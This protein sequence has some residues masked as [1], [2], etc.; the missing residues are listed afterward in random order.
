MKFYRPTL[1]YMLQDYQY[2]LSVVPH[3]VYF[4]LI[5]NKIPA[6]V[7]KYLSLFNK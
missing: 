6:D 5:I 3:R 4:E 1:L 2:G 7:S